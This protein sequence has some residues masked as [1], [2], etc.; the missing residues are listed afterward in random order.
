MCDPAGP[1]QR[2]KAQHVRQLGFTLIEII[3]VLVILGILAAVAIPRYQSLIDEGGKSVAKGVV[4]ATQSA[5][6]LKYSQA[7]LTNP[8]AFG[9][10]DCSVITAADISTTDVSLVSVS[11]GA[12][13]TITVRHDASGQTATGTWSKP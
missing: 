4:S 13:C 10:F 3:A 11:D 5:L 12:V 7:L 2:P 8:N 1:H 6:T 9:T